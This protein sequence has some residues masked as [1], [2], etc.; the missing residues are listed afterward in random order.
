[1][2]QDGARQVQESE[3]FAH[4]VEAAK[5]DAPPFD[6][7]HLDELMDQAGLD[8]LI[9]TSKH[10]IQYLLGGYRFFFFDYSD[11]IGLSRYLPALAYIRGRPDLA[12]YIGNGM[13]SYERDHGK[14]WVPHLDFTT[15]STADS[16]RIAARHLANL[17]VPLRRIGLERSFLPADAEAALR[18]ALPHCEYA[19]AVM[20]LEE[21]R[22]CKRPEELA[23]VKEASTRVVDAMLAV[24][25]SHGA[26]A[27]KAEIAEALRLEEVKRG[28]T[29]EYCL[30]AAG[31]SRNRAPSDQAWREGEVL[32]LDSG[33]N[34]RGYIGDL[35][36]M[37]IL[38]DP[39]AELRDIL[40]D[41]DAIQQAARAPIRPGVTGRE[42]YETAEAVLARSPHRDG[43][44][45][46]AHGM[47][48]IPHEA[49]RLSS[50][51]PVPYPGE[52]FDAPLRAG[53]V[54]SIET[55]LP[56]LKRGFIKLEDTLALTAD[57]WEAYGDHGR[58]WNRGNSG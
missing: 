46:V 2:S 12:L 37:A 9:V 5:S 39:D 48:I 42:I 55:T 10:N 3:G 49:P 57:G 27:T 7:A 53:M 17:G 19:E 29:F 43:M 20:T 8:A 24:F 41:I 18:S 45:F 23:L 33:G 25:A 56:H 36:R 13:E 44:R 26:G 51:A 31:A 52:Y 34:Y 15:W 4:R 58:G 47:G 30:I 32:S 38:G 21:L 14:F 40:A 35:C 16:M 6:S 54:L 11:A 1:M 28:L 50:R 22:A